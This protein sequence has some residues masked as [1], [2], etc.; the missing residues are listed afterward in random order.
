MNY[1]QGSKSMNSFSYI[2]LLFMTNVLCDLVGRTIDRL[3][4]V[5]DTHKFWFNEVTAQYRLYIIS[6]H[7][8]KSDCVF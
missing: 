5:P 8:E 2:N 1:E 6:Y 4:N 3:P 7:H